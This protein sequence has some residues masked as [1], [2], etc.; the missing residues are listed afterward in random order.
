MCHL[1]QNE[2][3]INQILV[4]TETQTDLILFIFIFIMV[5]LQCSQKNMMKFFFLILWVNT[6]G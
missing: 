5:W 1:E 6:F 2:Q 3:K 4:H